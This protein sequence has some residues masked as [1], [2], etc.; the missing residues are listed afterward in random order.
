MNGKRLLARFIALALVITDINIVKASDTEDA[1]MPSETM[2]IVDA[3][4]A[5]EYTSIDGKFKFTLDTEYNYYATIMAYLGSESSI[6]VPA[7]ITCSTGTYDVKAIGDLVFENNSTVTSITVEEGIVNIGQAFC[8]CPNL[9]VV[10]FPSTTWSVPDEAFNESVALK[11]INV[12]SGANSYFSRNGVLYYYYGNDLYLQTYPAGKTETSYT[13]DKDVTGIRHA[14]FRNAQNLKSISIPANIHKIATRA[15]N[16]ST[17]AVNIYFNPDTFDNISIFASDA[18]YGLPSGSKVIVK[19]TA[20]A[21][22]IANHLSNCTG[23]TIVDLSQDT[24]YQKPATSLTFSDG[25]AEM[26]KTLGIGE[27]DTTLLT[28]YTISPSDS[29]DN[30]TWTSDNENIATVNSSTGRIEAIATGDCTITGKDESNHILTVNLTV[31]LGITSVEALL[32]PLGSQTDLLESAGSSSIQY[33]PSGNLLYEIVI[34]PYN[35]Y[36]RADITW[37]SSD[38]SIATIVPDHSDWST[39][40]ANENYYYNDAIIKTKNLGTTTI[41]ATINGTIWTKSFV[42]NV[43]KNL[44]DCTITIPCQTYTGSELRPEVIVEDGETRLKENKHYR[45]IYS[46]N[47]LEYLI[48]AGTKKVTIT[49]IAGSLYSGSVSK[50]FTVNKATCD[51]S[52]V[53]WTNTNL[54]YNGSNQSVT[55]IGL[56]QGVTATYSGNTK[57]DAG[58]YTATANLSYDKENYNTILFSPNATTWYIRNNQNINFSSKNVSKS[59]ITVPYGTEDFKL[60]CSAKTKLSYNGGSGKVATIDSKGKISIKGTGYTTITVIAK[61]TDTYYKKSVT[62]TV[63]VTPKQSAITY[64]KS[65]KKSELTVKW[66]KDKRASGYQIQYSTS[67]KFTK[68][69][70][71]TVVVGKNTTTDQ[72]VKKLLKGKKYY[73]RVRAYKTVTVSGLEVKKCGKWSSAQVVKVQRK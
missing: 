15:F 64:L 46:Q 68:N 12:A 50:S 57:K 10:N 33:Q 51:M 39:N 1:S 29:T 70:T 41:T 69:T 17:K 26:S 61:Q 4:G 54:S 13:I 38:Q 28:S 19:N 24:S 35:A 30:V 23:T 63:F 73:V 7:Q 6:V 59:V 67:S 32:Y 3:T 62:L 40:A 49:A 2:D 43:T 55:M 25:T 18:F 27:T 44:S 5:S 65:N 34:K 45:I 53:K 16:A 8:G 37:N 47:S 31:Y 22:E 14:A 71:N 48:G 20:M 60:G 66:N 72:K 9:Q 52:Q 36:N 21:T 42:L 11:E 56:P 58:K